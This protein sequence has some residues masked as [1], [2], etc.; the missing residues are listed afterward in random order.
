MSKLLT[1]ALLSCIAALDGCA[2]LPLLQ[3]V[4]TT[5]YY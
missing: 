2:A 3:L 1:L 5:I 4:P